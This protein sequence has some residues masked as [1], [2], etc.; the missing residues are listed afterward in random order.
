MAILPLDNTDHTVT[1]CLP[2]AINVISQVH[3]T[4]CLAA[5]LCLLF[6]LLPLLSRVIPTQV[7][8]RR[9]VATNCSERFDNLRNANKI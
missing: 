2:S 1:T 8:L 3:P 4:A 5:V 9:I 7:Q 6:N